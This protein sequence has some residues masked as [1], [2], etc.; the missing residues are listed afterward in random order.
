MATK[1]T[2]KLQVTIPKTIAERYD[3][4]P[5]QEIEWLQAG[6]A[7]R[8]VPQRALRRPLEAAA[9]LEMFDR[10]TA[11]QLARKSGRPASTPPNGER[12]WTREELYERGH[13]G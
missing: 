3:I 13:T 9:R 11:R 4:A 1:V 12:G 8:V 10:A 6:D 5:G 7:I 2:S